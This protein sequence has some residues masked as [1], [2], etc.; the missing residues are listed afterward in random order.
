MFLFR[1][2]TEPRS[3]VKYEYLRQGVYMPQRYFLSIT[4]YSI[5]NITDLLKALLGNSPVNAFQHK[6][7]ETI[8]RKCF[9]RVRA[10][11]V[12]IQRMSC[13]VTQECVGIT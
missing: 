1:E 9:L 4:L 13:D 5:C 2:K 11:T 7:H 3:K 10:W 12:A 8:L 6:R